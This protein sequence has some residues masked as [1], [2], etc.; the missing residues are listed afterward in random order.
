MM[1]PPEG[2]L[3]V[4]ADALLMPQS[5]GARNMGQE[6]G[7]L[8]EVRGGETLASEQQQRPDGVVVG[9]RVQRLDSGNSNSRPQRDPVVAASYA[10]GPARAG[11]DAQDQGLGWEGV[12]E[13]GCAEQ[14]VGA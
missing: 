6:E 9:V 14:S 13:T 10:A 1:H 8:A 4:K 12:M 5:D 7:S 11:R 2:L 3:S